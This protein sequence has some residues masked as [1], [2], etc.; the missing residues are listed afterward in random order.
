[1]KST[2]ELLYSMGDD[3]CM[4]KARGTQEPLLEDIL[5]KNKNTRFGREH[6]FREIKDAQDFRQCVPLSMYHDVAPYIRLMASGE[7][8][9][10]VAEPYTGWVETVEASGDITV[11][12]YTESAAARF[13]NAFLHIFGTRAEDWRYVQDKVLCGLEASTTLDGKL[14]GSMLSLGG[15]TL[16]KTPVLN[17]VV[18]PDLMKRTTWKKTWKHAVHQVAQQNV[19]C[20]VVDPV[21]FTA[22]LHNVTEYTGKD[23]RELWPYFSLLISDTCPGPY[24]HMFNTIWDNVECRELF[25]TDGMVTGVQ[26]DEK[27]ITPLYD[28]VFFEFIPV[29]QW[30]AMVREGES[31]REFDFDIKDA[32]TVTSGEYVLAVTA[33]GLYRYISGDVVKVMDAAHMTQ[34]GFIDTTQVP[35]PEQLVLLREV[36][37]DGLSQDDSHQLVAVESEP[38]GYLFGI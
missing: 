29:K 24:K 12:P 31:Y 17:N 21:L 35:V 27:G 26:T 11:F 15:Y 33:P 25:S 22:F 3:P 18:T 7:A 23:M 5:E 28:S 30:A 19:F 8:F 9:A 13:R 38:L 14:T 32:S 20:A 34:C 10:L 2:L 37:H 16:G 4:D 6:L 1:M 36:A